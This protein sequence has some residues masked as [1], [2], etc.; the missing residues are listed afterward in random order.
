MSVEEV[1]LEC[2]RLAERTAPTPTPDAL[3]DAAR[4]YEAFA[5]GGADKCSE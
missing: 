5:L 1:R 4:R 3:L 2:L